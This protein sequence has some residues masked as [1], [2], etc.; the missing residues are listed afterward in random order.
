MAAQYLSITR[1]QKEITRSTITYSPLLE[2]RKQ[3][4]VVTSAIEY[5]TAASTSTRII[6]IIV[7]FI[8][9]QIVATSRSIAHI[10][11]AS[12]PGQIQSLHI[13]LTETSLPELN[14]LAAIVEIKNP[15]IHVSSSWVKMLVLYRDA[16]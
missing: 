3:I 4:N 13:V 1:I 11:Y 10:R 9:A 8:L 12:I 15:M 2:R 6:G 5:K 16:L 7:L 14:T